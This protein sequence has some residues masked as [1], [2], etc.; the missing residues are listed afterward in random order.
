MT[1]IT[2]LIL[3]GAAAPTVEAPQPALIDAPVLTEE[4]LENLNKWTG[5]VNAG[6]SIATGNT[7]E[8]SGH[9]ALDMSRRGEKDRWTLGASWNYGQQKDLATGVKTTSQRRLGG[10]AQYDYFL[11]EKSYA[12][13][14]VAGENDLLADLKLRSTVGVGYGYQFLEQD[15]LKVAGEVGLGYYKKDYYHSPSEEYPNARLAYNWE[16]RFGGGETKHWLAAQDFSALPSLKSGDQIYTR[17]DTRLRYDMS[18]AWYL[19]LQHIWEWDNV[20]APGLRRSD[21]RVLGSVGYSF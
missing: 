20:P 10:F 21:N 1:L 3:A 7:S 12:L 5:S 11:S 17:L 14:N 16:Y 8:K 19:Q 9:A 4:E 13:A 2:A 6:G 18:A 15:D